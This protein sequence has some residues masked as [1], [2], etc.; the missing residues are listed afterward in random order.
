[1]D[2]NACIWYW[3][4]YPGTTLG[5]WFWTQ[6]GNDPRDMDNYVSMDRPGEYDALTPFP[7]TARWSLRMPLLLTVAGVLALAMGM[8]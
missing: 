2:T 6:P 7:M 8:L 3:G 1:M 4:T 5:G